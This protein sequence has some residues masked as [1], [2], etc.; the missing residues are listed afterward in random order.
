MG[1][2]SLRAD[3]VRRRDS[4]TVLITARSDT[5]RGAAADSA[6]GRYA[7][8]VGPPV[9]AASYVNRLLLGITARR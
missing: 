2:D 1:A 8:G 3:T 5:L 4:R 7:S 9:R 6:L